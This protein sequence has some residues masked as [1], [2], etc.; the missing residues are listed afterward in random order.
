MADAMYDN[1]R[2]EALRGL[3]TPGSETIKVKAMTS[4]YTYSA[5]HT[6]VNNLPAANTVFT[7]Q[8]LTSKTFTAGVFDASDLT[9]TAVP[10]GSAIASLVIY[11]EAGSSAS[12][13]LMIYIDT[14]TGLPLTPN[15][16]DVIVTWDNGT[17]KIY[18]L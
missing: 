4:A 3:R 2:E 5:A 17:N 15:G 14:A 18:K 6:N 10:A 12:S 16:G 7:S 9:L 8:A 11:T 1:Y 13:T